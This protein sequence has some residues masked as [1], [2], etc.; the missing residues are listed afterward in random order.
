MNVQDIMTT[1]PLSCGPEANLAELV[2]RMWQA[3]CGIVP[4]TDDA[5][6]V[7]GV[8]T[9]RDIAVAAATRD[10][11][12]SH[13]RAAELLRHGAICCHVGD[14]VRAALVLMRQHRVRRLPVLGADGT[15]AG[16]VSMNDIVLELKPGCGLT[17]GEVIAALQAIGAHHHPP[18]VAAARPRRPGRATRGQTSPASPA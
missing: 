14:D 9:D 7:L 4:I 2:H 12:P 11:P 1:A 6:R 10:K 16:I 13:I 8:V 18:A 5:G 3:D 17:P 15:L